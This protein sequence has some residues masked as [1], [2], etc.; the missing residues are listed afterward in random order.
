MAR[1]GGSTATVRPHSKRSRRRSARVESSLGDPVG[2]EDEL[3]A[4][5]VEGVEGVEELLFGVR[6]A[7]EELDVVD[8]QDV[9][10]AVAVLEGLGALRPQRVDELVG[11]RLGGRVADAEP[12]RVGAEVVGDRDQQVGL[13]EPGRAVEE[14]RVVGLRGGLGDGQRGGVGE[15]VAVADHEAL[16]GVARVEVSAA[17]LGAALEGREADLGKHR[18]GGLERFADQGRVAALDPG[19]DAVGRR[20]VEGGAARPRAP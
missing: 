1:L 13:A 15:A 5:L 19:A 3:A 16:E 2:G 11:E 18:P 8:Q 9:E 6:L 7:L 17:L 4:P 14:E 12:G 20:E 10:V